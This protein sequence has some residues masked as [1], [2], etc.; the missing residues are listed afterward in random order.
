MRTVLLV[1]LTIVVIAVGAGV[2]V[3]MQPPTAQHSSVAERIG[4]RPATAPA[5]PPPTTGPSTD[6]SVLHSGNDVWVETFDEKTAQV[7]SRFRVS[8][9]DPQ[10]DGTVNVTDPQAEFFMT[11]GQMVRIEGS[12]GKVIMPADAA[13]SATSKG[14]NAPPSRGEL[15]NVTISQFPPQNH[16]HPALVCKVNNVSFD[17]DTFRIA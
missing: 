2:Y 3:W 13:K 17:N 5:L 6:Q 4:V 11:G 14:P 7:A 12:H 1:I 15:Y 10:A 8:R 16:R 9:Y